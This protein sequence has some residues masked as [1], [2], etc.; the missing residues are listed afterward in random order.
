MSFLEIIGKV[1]E[2]AVESPGCAYL[3]FCWRY[4]DDE[5]CAYFSGSLALATIVFTS[6]STWKECFVIIVGKFF[7]ANITGNISWIM[8]RF[9]TMISCRFWIIWEEI[10]NCFTKQEKEYSYRFD[11]SMFEYGGWLF[12]GGGLNVL[13]FT[14][15]VHLLDQQG[16]GH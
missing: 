12:S 2:A 10:V 13:A 9:G 5:G 6:S 16:R 3:A 8:R 4:L 14:F 15:L 1:S 7:V 11:H